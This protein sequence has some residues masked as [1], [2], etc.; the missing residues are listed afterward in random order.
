MKQ[1]I[2]SPKTKAI[3]PIFIFFLLFFIFLGFLRYGEI[4]QSLEQDEDNFSFTLANAYVQAEE[5]AS[6]FFAHRGFSIVS[7]KSIQDAFIAKDADAI[8]KLSQSTWVELRLENPFL[9]D[10]H[11]YDKEF[12]PLFSFS[13]KLVEPQVVKD[14]LEG[15]SYATFTVTPQTFTYNIFV[16]SF[17]NGEFLGMV[18]F[19]LGVEY[20]LDFMKRTVGIESSIFVNTEMYGFL[21][22]KLPTI[23]HFQLFSSTLPPSLQSSDVFKDLSACSTTVLNLGKRVFSSHIF[24]VLNKEGQNLARFVFLY[25]TTGHKIMLFSWI[26]NA[27]IVLFVFVILSILVLNVQ[28]N[29]LIGKL[30]QSEDALIQINKTLED[31]IEE[32]TQKRLQKEEENIE[33]ERIIVHQD[34]LASM[35]EMI[36]NIAH[37]WRQPLTELGSLFIRLEICFEQKLLSHQELK[38]ITTK[39]EKLISY[40][41]QTIDDF[42]NFFSSSDAVANFCINDAFDQSFYL[43][44]AALKNHYIDVFIEHK[45][46]LFTDGKPSEFSQAV[47]N[48]LNNAKDILCER[49]I[50][51]PT[52]WISIFLRDGK[53]VIRIKDNGGGIH[54]DPISKIFEPYITSKHASSGTGIGLYM[55]RNIIAKHQ[56]GSLIAFNE[57][58]GAVFEIILN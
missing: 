54:F 29:I 22:E 32:E 16:P 55:T 51:N 48:I 31:R 42:R 52:I 34:K 14:V 33:K 37:Q 24:Y 10:M 7:S 58:D 45:D 2:F 28:F 57:D 36:G 26:L 1:S 46:R 17:Y 39:A 15:K 11:F 47:L 23:C 3:V 43:I 6:I 44:S 30:K 21:P 20:F 50:K 9:A 38:N 13:Q 35:G 56:N 41:S 18:E 4:K 8:Q 27:L 19:V 40:M 49:Q 25:E 5:S 12:M 53:K